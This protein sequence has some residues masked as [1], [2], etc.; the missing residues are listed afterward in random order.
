MNYVEVTTR[1]RNIAQI[2]RRCPTATLRFAFVQA[3]QD[4]CNQTHWLHKD[5]TAL[6]AF[7]SGAEGAYVVPLS[8]QDAQYLEVIAIKGNIIGIDTARANAEFKIQPSDPTTWNLAADPSTPRWYAYR[9]H[10]HYDLYPTPDQDFNYRITVVLQ[11]QDD[12]RF[13]PEDI[14]KKHNGVIEAG[15]MAYLFSIPKQ[16]WSDK[17]EAGSQA[18]AFQAGINNAKADAQ[19]SHNTGSQRVRPRRFLRG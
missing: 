9:P 12:T 18:K 4:F 3:M 7:D 17:A 8:G 16:P 5:I 2:V 10:A 15:T 13:V 1:L 6:A 14:L 19:R 11:P